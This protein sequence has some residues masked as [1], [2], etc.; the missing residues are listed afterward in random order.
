MSFDEFIYR[1]KSRFASYFNSEN[2]FI[3]L[4]SRLASLA[5]FAAVISTIAPTIADELSSSSD[6]VETSQPAPA[7]EPT[8]AAPSESPA[9][10]ETPTQEPEAQID[11]PEIANS[12]PSALAEPSDSATVTEVVAQPLENQ[13][14]YT[15]R[16]PQSVA[17]DPR[18]KSYYLA[19]IY[20]SADS[21]PYTLA[22]ISGAGLSFDIRSKLT[23]QNS[24][25]GKDL[26]SGDQSGFLLISGSTARVVNL[27]NSQAGL[28]ISS[29]A[30]SLPNKVA[31]MR[32]IALTAP[33]IDPTFCSAARS[34]ANTAIRPLGLEQ[35]TIKGGGRLK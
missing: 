26:I 34:S 8:E 1:L 28:M 22:C 6:I 25:E 9:P 14:R 29:T 4:A 33:S 16:I 21:A 19:H 27:I 10:S 32:F 2:K 12:S 20:A 5:I 13:P 3:R 17:V 35:S 30:G 11:R 18:A 24:D 7:I 15:L 23:A 31:T